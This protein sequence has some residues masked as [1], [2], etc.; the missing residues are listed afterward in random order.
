MAGLDATPDGRE[1]YRHLGFE[2]IYR[3]ERHWAAVRRA[4]RSAPGI[5]ERRP[6]RPRTT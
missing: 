6:R 5:R 4:G 1:V 3:I 2:D